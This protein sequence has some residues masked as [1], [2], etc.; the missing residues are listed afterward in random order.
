M[1]IKDYFAES[2]CDHMWHLRSSN[3]VF[4]FFSKRQTEKEEKEDRIVIIIAMSSYK[5]GW[6][7]RQSRLDSCACLYFHVHG[8][9]G[10]LHV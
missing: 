1:E 2:I 9:E 6:W 10:F 4:F 7:S 5:A 8:M 3:Q